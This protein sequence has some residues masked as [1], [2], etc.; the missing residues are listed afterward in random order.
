M[1]IWAAFEESL[2]CP[3]DREASSRSLVLLCH[4]LDGVTSF[5]IFINPSL[6]LRRTIRFLSF[7]F[8][9]N[10]K[11]TVPC[12]YKAYKKMQNQS[13]TV[14][15]KLMRPA[16][17]AFSWRGFPLLQRAVVQVQQTSPHGCSAGLAAGT[18]FAACSWQKAGNLERLRWPTGQ[19]KWWWSPLDQGR[20]TSGQSQCH[21]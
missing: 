8:G 12:G 6:Q 9:G 21:F 1:E 5:F 19:F 20:T 3:R 13:V 14:E 11:S 17:P 4:L 15:A 16:L 2:K 18:C 10:W 7:S